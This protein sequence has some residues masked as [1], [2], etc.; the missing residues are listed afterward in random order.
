MPDKAALAVIGHAFHS[1]SPERLESLPETMIVVGPEGDIKRV[2]APAETDYAALKRRYAEEGILQALT[3]GQYLLPGFIDLHIHAP[4]WPQAGKALHLPLYEWLQDNTF[5][6]ESRYADL[7]FSRKIYGPM[8]DDLLANG[9]TTA[10]YFA[11]A[12]RESSLILAE[13]CLAR[14]QRGLVGRVAMDY[15]S[16]DFYK[17]ASAAQGIEETK[18]FIEETLALPG[19]VARLVRPVVTPRFIPSCSEELLTGLGE[20]ARE[21]DCH[22]QSHCSE[23]DWAH[24]HVLERL[25]KRPGRALRHRRIGGARSD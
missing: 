12:H 2:V 7:E 1:V 11:T 25:G 15:D 14:G 17:D 22:V 21:Y 20:L 9:T 3:S 24:G 13:E 4:Q 8:V 16:P 18:R 23:S 5:I 10:L 6:L 19:N